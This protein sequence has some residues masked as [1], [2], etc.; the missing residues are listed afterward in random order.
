MIEPRT[1]TGLSLKLTYNTK[2]IFIF[3]QELIAI[4]IEVIDPFHS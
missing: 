3:L 2:S 1:G 4:W